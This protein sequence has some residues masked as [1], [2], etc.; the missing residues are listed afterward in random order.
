MKKVAYDDYYKEQN[1]FGSPYPG[2]IKFFTNYYP[3]G[4]VLD[5]GCGQGRD[6]LLLGEIGFNVIGVDHSTVGIK[7]LN[8]E[9]TK[10]QLTVKGLIGD[11]YE[12]PITKNID[13]I[14]LDSILH[15]YK[16]D[17]EKETKFARKI[18]EELR[19]GGVFVN[20]ILKG[21][22]RER[23]LKNIIQASHFKW[24]ILAEF[25]TEFSESNTEFHLLAIKKGNFIEASDKQ[26][27][28]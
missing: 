3:K 7:Q 26:D 17:L 13:L 2:L 25:Y 16:N 28:N 11:I 14:L 9:A 10:R 18:L 5:L 23:I 21:T 24:E 19:V 1:Y 4:T 8:N 20:C 15:F 6:S 22:T 27:D 12:F